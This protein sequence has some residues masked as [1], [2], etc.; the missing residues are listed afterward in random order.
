MSDSNNFYMS[1]TDGSGEYV[2]VA[3][4]DRGRVGFRALNGGQTRVR[5]EP[6]GE[7]VEL[8]DCFPSWKQPVEGLVR[9]SLV[10]KD[11]QSRAAAVRQGLEAIG[12]TAP[13]LQ[14]NSA[15]PEW[16]LALLAAPPAPA[17]TAEPE[18]DEDD[19]DV[20]DAADAAETLAKAAAELAR[21]LRQLRS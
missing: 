14:V 6:A 15:A 17:E 21:R 9:F 4:T 16:A 18:S 10:C 2:V 8:A 5:V 7:P 19:G 11:E 1:G 12:A 20:A 13:S 3:A